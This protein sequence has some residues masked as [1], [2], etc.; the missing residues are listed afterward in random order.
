MLLIT[1]VTYLVQNL[2]INTTTQKFL[3]F[4]WVRVEVFQ[5]NLKYLHVKITCLHVKITVTIA[6]THHEIIQL[7]EL[8]TKWQKKINFQSL[9]FRRFKN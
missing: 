2:G 7:H 6:T 4:D 8:R 9:K 3:Q 1:W 5:L